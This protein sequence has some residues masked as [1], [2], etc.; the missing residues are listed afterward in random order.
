MT[1]SA[2]VLGYLTAYLN[3]LVQVEHRNGQ[4]KGR[5]HLDISIEVCWCYTAHISRT[6]EQ[7]L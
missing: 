2:K 6:V 7:D 4:M 5:G 3:L 1:G